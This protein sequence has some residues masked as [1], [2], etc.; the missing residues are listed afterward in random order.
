MLITN[1]VFGPSEALNLSTESLDVV[2]VIHFP[3]VC[4]S[5]CDSLQVTDLTQFLIEN[6]DILGENTKVLLDTDEGKLIS[7]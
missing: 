2:V 6:C 4:L 7:K 3:N 1:R 5:L